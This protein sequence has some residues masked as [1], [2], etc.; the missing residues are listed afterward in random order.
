[1]IVKY[2]F[3]TN[4][5]ERD[6]ERYVTWPYL[7]NRVRGRAPLGHV[8]RQAGGFGDSKP[9]AYEHEENLEDVIKTRALFVDELRTIPESERPRSAGF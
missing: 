3:V 2:A 5:I 6:C 9:H 7:E 1:L 8:R 4:S